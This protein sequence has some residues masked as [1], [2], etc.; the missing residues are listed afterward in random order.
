MVKKENTK[1]FQKRQLVKMRF[2]D[3][4][5]YTKEKFHRN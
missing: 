1:I 2:D 4:K 5:I 3:I